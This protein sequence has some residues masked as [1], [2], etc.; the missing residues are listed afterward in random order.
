[1][2]D[3]SICRWFNF[4]QN[5]N[6][7][8]TDAPCP[9]QLKKWT[10]AKIQ[11]LRQALQHDRK[12]T[13]RQLS[14][15]ISLSLRTTHKMLWKDLECTKLTASWIPHLLTA[16]QQNQRVVD[17]RVSLRMLG[18]QGIVTH[19][20]CGDEAWFHV[21]DPDSR[22]RNQEW[23]STRNGDKCPKVVQHEQSIAKT[24]LVIFFDQFGLVHREFVPNGVGINGPL[25][26]QIMQN[27]CLKICCTR[28]NEFQA[29]SWGLLHD[30]APVHRSLPVC[31][32]FQQTQTKVLPHPPTV[33]T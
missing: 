16:A 8:L 7:R 10:P 33:L 2:S 22:R 32:F 26:L 11:Q 1:M 14:G 31:C 23:I 6:N 18:R 15:W 9:G 30:G 21:W 28:R 12:Q 19:V 27:L 29:N 24:M 3:S 13:V 4:F 17:A 5:G 20:V 25:Y